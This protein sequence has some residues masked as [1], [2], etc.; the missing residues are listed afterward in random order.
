M[1]GESCEL[2]VLL[3]KAV[4]QGQRGQ[5]EGGRQWRSFRQVSES[6]FRWA[7]SGLLSPS[8]SLTH[9]ASTVKSGPLSWPLGFPLGAYS[10]T[11]GSPFAILLTLDQ[12]WPQEPGWKQAVFL[13]GGWAM[14]S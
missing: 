6:V 9:S 7:V 5:G 2:L 3:G 14:V 13:P 8:P 4:G 10:R 1:R 12:G 11:Q